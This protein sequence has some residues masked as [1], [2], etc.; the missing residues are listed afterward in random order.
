MFI[1]SDNKE[2]SN[3]GS[4]DGK[5]ISLALEKCFVF[6]RRPSLS[7]EDSV[8]LWEVQSVISLCYFGRFSSHSEAI[9]V[10]CKQLWVFR[11]ECRART[12]LPCKN[13]QNKQITAKLSTRLCGGEEEAE[14][15]KGRQ[16]WSSCV[17]LWQLHSM[18]RGRRGR[19]RKR[20]RLKV[21]K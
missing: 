16:K 15:W 4:L 1:R 20:K 19:E 6:S 13:K 3:G 10:R 7:P 21:R 11:A 9:Y 5:V 18:A 2:L 17:S 8:R 14:K 12:C